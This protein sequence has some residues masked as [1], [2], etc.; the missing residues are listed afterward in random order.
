MKKQVYFP[1]N[2]IG[3][4]ERYK[5]SF[6]KLNINYDRYF[7]DSNGDELKVEVIEDGKTLEENARKKAEAYY[8]EYKKYINT[9]F[10]VI[11]TD[12]ALYI[13]GLEADKQPGMFVRRFNGLDDKRASDEE[14]VERYT[15]FVRSL[16]GEARARWVYQLVMYDGI[17]FHDYTWNEDVLFSDTPHYPITKGY[18]LNNITIID[19][20]IMLSDL[21][22][23]ERY[24]YLSKYTD[25]VALF[26][27]NNMKK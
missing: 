26:V 1:T 18:V 20:D 10:V 21:S 24:N 13:D 22:K 12:E 23:E 19:K 27:N 8:D 25:N 3:K 6:E 2:N 4:Y 5:K 16:G 9:S 11:T 14:V 17:A 7:V 15:S